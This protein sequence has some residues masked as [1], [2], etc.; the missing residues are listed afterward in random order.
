MDVLGI[1]CVQVAK[2]HDDTSSFWN[3]LPCEY[4]F[5]NLPKCF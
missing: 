2:A 4:T 5:N 3:Q 1:A